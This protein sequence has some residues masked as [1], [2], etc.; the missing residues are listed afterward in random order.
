M[1]SRRF[2]LSGLLRLREL[3]ESTAA[4]ALH[5]DKAELARGNRRLES[6]RRR[7]SEA[8]EPIFDASSL[9]AVAANRASYRSMLTEHQALS[10][11][12]LQRAHASEEAHAQARQETK[13]VQKL[14]EKHH[15]QVTAEEL[16]AEQLAIDESAARRSQGGLP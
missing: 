14:Q 15:R 7:A 5:S 16:A 10:E 12:L 3:R 6:L 11:A 8:E 4:G 1:S 9:L 2:P 13:A